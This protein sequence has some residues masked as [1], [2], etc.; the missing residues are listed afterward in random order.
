MKK[1]KIMLTA[2]TVFAIIGGALAFKAKKFNTSIYCTD[3]IST[4]SILKDGFS[5]QPAFA[6]QA[7]VGLSTCTDV[8]KGANCVQR[9]TYVNQ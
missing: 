8:F 4:C 5:T 3:G 7:S 2:I 1:V 6:G 9:A